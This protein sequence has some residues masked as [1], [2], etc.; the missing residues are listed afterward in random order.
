[1]YEGVE[2]L[3]E[4]IDAATID[5]EEKGQSQYDSRPTTADASARPEAGE[6]ATSTIQ[7]SE[8]A[9]LISRINEKGE[10]SDGDTLGKSSK[11]QS[12]E[13]S[14]EESSTLGKSKP[15]PLA[16]DKRVAETADK[17]PAKVEEAKAANPFVMPTPAITY[18]PDDDDDDEVMTWAVQMKPT[19]K[20]GETPAKI[21]EEVTS[22]Q[23][24]K[25]S[26]SSSTSAHVGRTEPP[27]HISIPS[28]ALV[29]TASVSP[30]VERPALKLQTDMLGPN[31]TP[32]QKHSPLPHAVSTSHS[33]KSH[34]SNHTPVSALVSSEKQPSSAS[35]RSAAR[36]H[37]QSS[38][39]S[40]SAEETNAASST[41]THHSHHS[42]GQRKTSDNSRIDAP[43]NDADRRPSF[44]NNDWAFRPPVEQ[45][46]ENL[47]DFFPG[48]DLDKPIVDVGASGSNSA[49]SSPAQ[50]SAPFISPT[51]VKAA[52]DEESSSPSTVTQPHAHVATSTE[53]EPLLSR[54]EKDS[55][56]READ[57]ARRFNHNRKSMRM[58]AHDR[59]IRMKREETLNKAAAVPSSSKDANALKLARRK[60]TKVW[61]RKIEEVTAAE[62]DL[63]HS[64]RTDASER[65]EREYQSL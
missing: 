42:H 58:V 2:I 44:D 47:E 27:K 35:P 49:V 53:T 52:V 45:V 33:S 48:H 11:R 61:G 8:W 14:D 65:D 5:D 62:A 50:E 29:E 24:Q 9:N 23:K 37:R 18:N 39:D 10:G 17:K 26:A 60:S 30:R 19:K 25:T 31:G 57:S 34:K 7:A 3:R 51:R 38:K 63:L 28:S 64:A 12:I 43:S 41:S 55:S 6:E 21:T 54:K 4:S 36:R 46:Y 15:S 13:K 32:P 56:A 20:P 16:L 40:L 22:P 1:M 59:K